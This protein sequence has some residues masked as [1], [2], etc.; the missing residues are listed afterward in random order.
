[1]K[2]LIVL[3]V[4]L[5]TLVGCQHEQGISNMDLEQ[6]ENSQKDLGSILLEDQVFYSAYSESLEKLNTKKEQFVQQIDLKNL[7]YKDGLVVIKNAEEFRP[8]YEQTAKVDSLWQK[9]YVDEVYVLVE[10][11][12][13]ITELV[14]QVKDEDEISFYIQDLLERD[15][16][17]FYDLQKN[18]A[19]RM[20]IKTLWAKVRNES[21]EWLASLGEK[22]NWEENPDD[23]YPADIYARL[24]LNEENKINIMG[25]VRTFDTQ[26][27]ISE[28]SEKTQGAGC[29]TFWMTTEYTDNTG[30][31]T[32][33]RMRCYVNNFWIWKSYGVNAKGWI[34]SGGRWRE[35]GF[36]KFLTQGGNIVTHRLNLTDQCDP[37]FSRN[38]NWSRR[39]TAVEFSISN[40]LWGP[41]VYLGACRGS[42]SGVVS[43]R[44]RAQAA[45]MN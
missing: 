32:C 9:T 16:V 3:I 24:F 39:S 20:P 33:L 4:L 26:K 2:K 36:N 21:N 29:R 34:W 11:A 25:E 12:S 8:I 7:K 27:A 35:W 28:V 6:N 14:E 30:E 43:G 38:V 10:I 40:T 44:G 37:R 23:R 13:N 22:P 31:P 15:K 42:F 41:S 5:G 1:M 18:V 17:G 19:Q 45:I